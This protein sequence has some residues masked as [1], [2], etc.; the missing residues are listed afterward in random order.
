MILSKEFVEKLTKSRK[1]I[2]SDFPGL[3]KDRNYGYLEFGDRKF[4]VIDT[5]GIAKDDSILKEDIADQA[6]VAA[7]QPAG[8]RCCL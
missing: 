2:V 8:L 4:F 5:G 3:T 1:A 7:D 6:W